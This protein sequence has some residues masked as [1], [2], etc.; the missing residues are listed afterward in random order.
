MAWSSSRS[1]LP[2]G[3][4]GLG[5]GQTVAVAKTVAEAVSVSVSEW[6]SE[7][8]GERERLS[9]RLVERVVSVEERHGEGQ[10]QR[11]REEDLL[12]ALQ[13]E[14]DTGKLLQLVEL[15]SRNTGIAL[16]SQSHHDQKD[17]GYNEENGRSTHFECLRSLKA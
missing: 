13:Q 15:S 9:D 5:G 2:V 12:L 1:V 17:G 14:S 8:L 7:R 3:A 11:E 6:F 16:G 4:S 10:G